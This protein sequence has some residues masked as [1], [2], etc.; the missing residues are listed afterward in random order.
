MTK[1]QKKKL[2]KYFTSQTRL[3][4][5]LGLDRR[6]V[7]QWFTGERLIPLKYILQIEKLTNGAIKLLDLLGDKHKCYQKNT[8]TI[9][10]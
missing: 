8:K 2:L 1:D 6:F 9:G 4:E 7:N 10:E 3:A 5:E